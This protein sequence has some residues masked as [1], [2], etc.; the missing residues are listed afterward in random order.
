VPANLAAGISA[1]IGNRNIG[2][3][4]GRGVGGDSCKFTGKQ[5]PIMLKPPVAGSASPP[6]A[7]SLATTEVI[8]DKMG[9]VQQVKKTVKNSVVYGDNGSG[10]TVTFVTEASSIVTKAGT[11]FFSSVDSRSHHLFP[12]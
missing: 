2:D 8:K 11:P 1:L 9:D 5:Q 10:V 3:S 12:N 4:F 6:R 7:I